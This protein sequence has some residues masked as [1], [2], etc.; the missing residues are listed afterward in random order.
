MVYGEAAAG[1]E[2]PENSGSV[3]GTQHFTKNARLLLVP[4]QGAKRRKLEAGLLPTVSASG[5]HTGHVSFTRTCASEA[6]GSS[7]RE[8]R[9]LLLY[10]QR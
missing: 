10:L 6:L 5:E 9:E 2:S 3:F 8:G 4:N 1:E 7:L